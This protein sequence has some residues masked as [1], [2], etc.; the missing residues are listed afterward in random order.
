VA[1]LRPSV[2]TSSTSTLYL[3]RLIGLFLLAL[4]ISMIVQPQ[5]TIETWI[6]LV[7][8]PSMVYVLG[9]ITTAAGLAMV[10]SHNVWRGGALPI[11]ITLIGWLTL[12]KGIAA[13]CLHAESAG[14]VFEMFHYVAFFYPYALV[15]I[16]SGVCLAIAG[17]RD[18]LA[19]LWSR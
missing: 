8:D 5:A 1:K 19:Q 15:C 3:A 10:L 16:V 7:R 6:A 13:L 14:R 18:A 11:A 4:G 2:T 17:F 12:L 9:M